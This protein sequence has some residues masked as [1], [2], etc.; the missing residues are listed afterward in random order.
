MILA[1]RPYE[2]EAGAV[3][4]AAERALRDLEEVMA[5]AE[6]DRPAALRRA[7]S[8]ID[9]V[10]TAGEDRPRVGIVGEIYV[11]NDPFINGDLVREIERLGGE[12]RLTSLSE[13]VLYTAYLR[14]QGFAARAPGV[15][16]RIG[17]HLSDRFLKGREH[18]F[19]EIARPHLGDRM[20][21][22]IDEIVEAGRRYVPVEFQG[23]AILTVGRALLFIEREKVGAVVNASPT[24]CMPGTVTA[25]I[26]PR[27]EQDLGVPIVSNF[28]DGTGDV[29]GKLVPHLHYLSKGT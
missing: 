24:F 29:N 27:I 26:F 15:L 8:A 1:R 6:A 11:R 22:G 23:E 14:D 4:V 17:E 10:P 28:Y 5:K 20:E 16:R 18:L 25:A 21:P 3:D 13:W 19:A 7:L 9:A 2:T 12:A